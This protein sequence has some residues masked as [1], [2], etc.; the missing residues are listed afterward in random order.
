LNFVFCFEDF[1]CRSSTLPRL[2][3]AVKKLHFEQEY[4]PWQISTI[5]NRKLSRKLIQ[6]LIDSEQLPNRN[7]TNIEYLTADLFFINGDHL[8]LQ[9]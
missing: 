5:R 9:C 1:S 2:F 6:S 7:Q 3:Y 8:F 4:F